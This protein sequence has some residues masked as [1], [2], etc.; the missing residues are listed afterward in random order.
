M[1]QLNTNRK[2]TQSYREQTCGDQREDLGV[3][4]GQTGSS[5][6]ADANYYIQGR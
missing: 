5:G 6:L 3:V 4:E 2:Q 1:I